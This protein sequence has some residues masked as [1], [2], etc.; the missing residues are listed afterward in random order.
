MTYARAGVTVDCRARV[1]V[2]AAGPW[3]T[4]VARA[5]EPAIPIPD[6]DLVQGTHIVISPSP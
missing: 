3:A 5:V 4:Q 1:L 2:N 6:V